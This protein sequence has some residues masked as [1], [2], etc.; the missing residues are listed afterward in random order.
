MFQFCCSLVTVAFRGRSI[1]NE[2]SSLLKWK[3]ETFYL[4]YVKLNRLIFFNIKMSKWM[5]ML[6]GIFPHFFFSTKIID[7]SSETTGAYDMPTV[8]AL[9]FLP[10]KKGYI[11]QPEGQKS[12]TASCWGHPQLMGAAHQQAS[13][14]KE[15]LWLRRLGEKIDSEWGKHNTAAFEPSFSLQRYQ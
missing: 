10:G 14:H 3:W 7:S 13:V 2:N 9:F 8:C 5:L 4:E 12:L 15:P 11:S 1:L 6:F